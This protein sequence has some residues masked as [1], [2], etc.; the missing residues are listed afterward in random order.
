M[1]PRRGHAPAV[2][3]HH[4]VGDRDRGGSV[5]D[6]D[7]GAAVHHGLHRGADL[8]LLR[9][10]DGTRGVVEHEDPRVGDDRPGDRDPLAL[11][12]RQRVPTLAD[13]R[14]VPVGELHHEV[15]G[16]G[17]ARR[18]LDALAVGGRVGEGDVGGD[19]VVEQ[20]RVLEHHADGA[21]HVVDGHVAH[22]DPVDLDGAA[23]RVVEP[24]QQPG[25]RR[26]ARTGLPDQRG[27]LA[28]RQLE[29]EAVEHR[30]AVSEPVP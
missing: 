10:I 12:A 3:Q 29:R 4:H 30:P 23:L 9:R 20:Q 6:D 5:G 14:V 24:Q 8:V 13:Q 11:S 28:G 26:L 21:A 27:R 2:E 15:V 25:D 18:R 7:R 16:A 17:Q 22:V 19:R 1:G